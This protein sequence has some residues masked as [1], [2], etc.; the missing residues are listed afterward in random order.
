MNWQAIAFDWNQVKAFMATAEEGSLSAA[1]RALRLTQPTLSRQVSALE[2]DLG[3]VLFERGHRSMELTSGGVEL[4]EHVRKMA[5]AATAI[6]LTATGHSDSIEGQVSITATNAFATHYLPPVIALIRDQAP[7]IEIEIIGSNQVQDLRRREADIAIRHAEPEHADL[8]GR[9]IGGTT[10]HL[11]AS[12]AYIKRRGRPKKAQDLIEHDFIG[13]EYPERMLHPFNA[14]GIPVQASNFKTYTASGTVILA[15]VEQG[16]G[17]SVLSKDI[18]DKRPELEQILPQLPAF[19]IPV[20]LVA[21]REL[22][23][24]RRIRIVYDIIANY[25]TD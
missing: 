12:K 16:L 15:L 5:E 3:I 7:G 8:I 25:F 17:I 11:Y 21:H 20:W 2:A 19:D 22:Y 6:S 14:M 23:T 10:G 13:F 9:R 4:L 18:A 1:A 24:S